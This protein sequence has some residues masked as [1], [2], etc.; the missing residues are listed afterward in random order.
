MYIYLVTYSVNVIYA[1]ALPF[2]ALRTKTSHNI[3]GSVACSAAQHHFKSIALFLSYQYPRPVIVG[4][5]VRTNRHV[6]RQQEQQVGN[7]GTSEASLPRSQLSPFLL[8]M[9]SLIGS[10]CVGPFT[11]MYKYSQ[12]KYS[13][14]AVDP[15]KPRTLNPAKNKAHTVALAN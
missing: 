10:S 8:R 11:V 6:C 2:F 14:M 3:P 12:T 4:Y 1:C 15:R 13:R 7:K 9:T 5:Q